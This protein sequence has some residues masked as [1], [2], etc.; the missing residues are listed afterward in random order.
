MASSSTSEPV[1]KVQLEGK[2]I[3]I[4]GANR[5]I[6]LGIADCCLSNGASKVY[7]LD[8]GTPGDDFS[9]LASKYPNQLFALE[10]D[11]TKEA[12]IQAAVDKVLS[13]AGALHG[14]VCNAGRTKH[15]PALDFTTEE[16]DQLWGVNLYGSFYSARCAARAFIKQG[17]KGSIVFTAS[18][19]SYR[20]NKRVPSAPYGAS[21]AGIRNMTHTLAMEWA[22]YNIRVNS[23]S[24]GLVKTA[25]TYWVEQQPDW[26]QQLKYYGGM[27]RLAAVEELG[28]AYVYLLSDAASYTTSIDI[29]VNGVIG[30]C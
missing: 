5:G 25:M 9:A 14:M 13:E 22:Q 19:A 7:S 1:K 12:S 24:P 16:I 15:K 8:I 23:V 21:K 3:A 4:T 17:V 10:A 26:E 28:G 27:P 11:V 18:M 6:G 20:P 30:I 29:P 2:V